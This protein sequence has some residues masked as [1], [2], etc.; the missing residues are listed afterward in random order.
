MEIKIHDNH[1]KYEE[2]RPNLRQWT[3][4]IFKVSSVHLEWPIFP[5]LYLVAYLS[6]IT[7]K[8]INELAQEL[9]AACQPHQDGAILLRA[10]PNGTTSKHTGLLSTLSH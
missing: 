10:F 6:S 5:I 7:R 8:R 4:S 2:W 1:C 9:P 3:V